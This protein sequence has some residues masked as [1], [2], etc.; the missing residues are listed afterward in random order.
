MWRGLAET[1]ANQR[2]NHCVLGNNDSGQCWTL[3]C[4]GSFVSLTLC[5]DRREEELGFDTADTA[6]APAGTAHN[7]CSGSCC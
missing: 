4:C 2:D 6:V 3:K 7:G 1:P 5:L